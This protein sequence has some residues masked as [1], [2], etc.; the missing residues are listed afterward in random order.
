MILSG[1]NKCETSIPMISVLYVV[2][3][4]NSHYAPVVSKTCLKARNNFD[5]ILLNEKNSG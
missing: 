1:L 5:N 3:R 2:I 4:V